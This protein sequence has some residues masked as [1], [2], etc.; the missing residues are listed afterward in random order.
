MGY[1][2]ATTI[3]ECCE[4]QLYDYEVKVQ[5][6]LVEVSDEL[7]IGTGTYVTPKPPYARTTIRKE[8]QW[9]RFNDD[10]IFH[11]AIM[12]G[13]GRETGMSSVVVSYDPH[14]SL[15]QEKYEFARRTV[16]NL[17]CFMFH[18][19]KQCGYSENTRTRLMRSFSV[20]KAQLASQSS[21]DPSMLTATSHFAMKSDTYLMDNARYDPYLR[22][23]LGGTNPGTTLIDMTDTVRKGLLNSLGYKAGE[24][25][26]M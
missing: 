8:L 2:I 11:T 15:Y 16:A 23:T 1:N 17:S 4:V 24:K 20:E 9:I 12:I 3:V 10:Q 25:R 18:W 6:E 22:K 5:M 13:K 7:G 19:L 14:D 21:W 26:A